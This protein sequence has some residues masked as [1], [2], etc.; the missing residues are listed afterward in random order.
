MSR[1]G[2]GQMRGSLQLCLSFHLPV[3]LPHSNQL[4]IN[5]SMFCPSTFFMSMC[6]SSCLPCVCVYPSHQPT[7]FLTELRPVYFCG[8]LSIRLSGMYLPCPSI[9]RSGN[10]FALLSNF[11]KPTYLY[12][13]P[14]ICPSTN[15]PLASLS[16]RLFIY[17]ALCV[18]I[19]V[20]LRAN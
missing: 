15:P 16:I 13:P 4:S 5:L 7:H 14:S 3:Y 17:L 6:P 2:R 9:Y 20:D 11:L 19:P 8:S 18:F 1:C 12:T 10:L